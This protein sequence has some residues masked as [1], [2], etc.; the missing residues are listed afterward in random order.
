DYTVP[1]GLLDHGVSQARYSGTLTFVIINPVSSPARRGTA[2]QP[3]RLPTQAL[4][5]VGLRAE[6]LLA[7]PAGH[8]YDL[9]RHAVGA[10]ADLVVAWGGDGT[11]NEVGRALAFS[12]TALGIVPAGS[13]NGLAREL[14]IPFSPRKALQHA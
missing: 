12:H 1:Q 10:G 6:I 5:Q 11:I 7:A 9:A 14:G 2:D 3:W 8:A 4:A 13:G